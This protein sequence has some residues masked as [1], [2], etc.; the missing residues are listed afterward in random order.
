MTGTRMNNRNWTTDEIIA[1][2]NH[3]IP[4]TRTETAA[5]VKASELG[6]R[7]KP[8]NPNATPNPP[9]NFALLK[10]RWTSE[11]IQALHEQRVPEGRSLAAAYGKAAKLHILFHPKITRNGPHRSRL[12]SELR[13]SIEAELLATRHI[14]ETARK[15][16]VSYFS[17]WQIALRIGVAKRGKAVE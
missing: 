7:F 15:F 5:R 8:N 16:G 2:C 12:V 1:L 13:S 9:V 17:T 11:Q 3:K 10:P 4:E 6:I 14:K